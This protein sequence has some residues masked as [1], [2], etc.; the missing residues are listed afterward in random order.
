MTY[1]KSR[2]AG[3]AYSSTPANLAIG[4]A[5]SPLSM[6]S[7]GYTSIR[8]QLFVTFLSSPISRSSLQCKR[9]SN[10]GFDPRSSAKKLSQRGTGA[11]ST[12]R[13]L[14][15]EPIGAASIP[16]RSRRHAAS[17]VTSTVV[18]FNGPIALW[19]PRSLRG[20][21]QAASYAPFPFDRS[22]SS[23]SQTPSLR[24][25]EKLWMPACRHLY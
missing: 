4:P 8:T 15:M 3:M 6:A 11:A 23:S 22:T 16:F 14:S 19:R 2:V 21:I 18:S 25:L 7:V 10:P 17:P 5:S 9:P 20:S 13:G 12:D 1:F 24:S